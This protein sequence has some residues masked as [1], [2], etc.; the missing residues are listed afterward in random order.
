M[1][2]SGF[3]WRF[4]GT[5]GCCYTVAIMYPSLATGPIQNTPIANT[6]MR[7]V[8]DTVLDGTALVGH[9][10]R[11]L[12]FG[13][14]ST[15]EMTVAAKTLIQAFYETPARHSYFTG[16]STGGHQ[17]LA[18]AQVFPD[19]YDG[20]LGEGPGHNRTHLHTAFVWDF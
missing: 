8:P 19:D 12:D 14:R 5:G 10:E 3:N 1:P 2:L 4:Q 7:T 15:Q 11:W 18:E 6:D 13:S 20:I 16:C 9:P 17:A